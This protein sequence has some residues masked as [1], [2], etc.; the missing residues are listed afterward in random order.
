MKTAMRAAALLLGIAAT[1]QAAGVA[2]QAPPAASV[3]G[4]VPLDPWPRKVD[5]SN[6]SVLV[7]QPQINKWEGNQLD[8][9]AAVAIQPVG[10][11]SETFGTFF[12]TARPY[13]LVAVG[14]KILSRGTP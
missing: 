8:F 1:L 2:A 3:P 11:K 14:K 12:A 4:Q 13:S 10:A 5:L 9:R 7:Y 6:A